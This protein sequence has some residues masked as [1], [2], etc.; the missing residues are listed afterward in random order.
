MA[1]FWQGLGHFVPF[2][3]FCTFYGMLKPD[4]YSFES[5]NRWNCS[6]SSVLR[7]ESS[8]TGHRFEFTCE[9]IDKHTSRN[10]SLL[11]SSEPLGIE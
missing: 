4:I 11:T 7:G 9:T 2:F 8:L 3:S 6:L 1:F 5:A 10:H